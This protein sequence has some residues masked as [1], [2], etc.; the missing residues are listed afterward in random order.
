MILHSHL[1]IETVGKYRSVSLCF[2][3]IEAAI[4]LPVRSYI[5][6]S[7]G[8]HEA[9]TSVSVGVQWLV[10]AFIV[11]ENGASKQI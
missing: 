3:N 1:H 8:S 2:Y 6:I 4:V 9:R 7:T 11:F 10:E 5:S